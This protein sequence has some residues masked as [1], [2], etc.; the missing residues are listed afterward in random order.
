MEKKY[1]HK[2]V[3]SVL[4]ERLTSTDELGDESAGYRVWEEGTLM[5]CSCEGE[6]GKW[7]RRGVWVSGLAVAG[8]VY[9]RV[10]YHVDIYYNSKRAIAKGP[11]RCNMRK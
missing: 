10:W 9:V 11:V 3:G 8:V 2:A 1:H 6:D 4:R 5:I 7:G